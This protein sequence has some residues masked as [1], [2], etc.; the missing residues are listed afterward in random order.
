MKRFLTTLM[1]AVIFSTALSAQRTLVKGDILD[2]LTRQGEPAAVLQFFR[3]DDTAHPVAFTTT[4]LDG[5]FSQVLTG[6]G[7]Y[8]LYFSGIGRQDC[9][10]PFTLDGEETLDLGEILIEDDIEALAEASVTAQRPLVKM[11]VDRMTYNVADD[12]DSKTATVLDM[13]RKVPMVTVDGQDNI[14]VNGSSSFQVTVDGKPSQ[15]FSGNPSQIFKMMPASSVK[16][17]QV[18]TNPGVRYDAEGVGGVLNLI[19]NRE[20]T[21]GQSMADAFYG[22]VRAMGSTRGGGGGLFLTRQAGKFAWS[23]NGN[24]MYMSMPGT[25]TDV[26]RELIGG[27]GGSTLTHSESA[28]TLPMGMGT[29]SASYEI[30]PQNLISATAGL[31]H[32]GTSMDGLTSTTMTNAQGATLFG[33]DGTSLM[34]MTSN[35][36]TA[37]VD[38]QHLWDDVPARSLIFSYQFSGTPSTSVSE[39]TFNAGTLAGLDLTSRKTDGTQGSFDHTFQV[40]FT[41][42]LGAGGTF[43]AGAKYISRRNSSDQQLYLRN[44]SDWAYSDAGSLDYNF[45]NRIGALYSEFK[46][47]FGPVSLLGGARY[48]YTWQS[49]DNGGNGFSTRYGSLVPTAS[50]QWNLGMTQNIGLSYNMRISRPGISY[51]NPYVDTSDPTARSYG[52]GELEVERG[53]NISLVYNLY[54]PDWIVN[55][56]LRETLV[57]NGISPYSFYDDR[58][59]LN[60]TYGN[61]V[62]SCTT[63]LNA[64]INWNA[65]PDTRIFLNG[66]LNYVDLRS[67]VLGQRNSGLSYNAMLGVQ[68]ALPADI[69]LSANVV[70][71]GRNYT[72]Q[73]WS[74]GMSMAMIGATKSFLDDR[75]GIS[76]NYTVPLSG[77]KGLQMKSVTEGRDFRSVSVNT[78]PMENLNFSISWSFGKQGGAHVKSAR[79][80]ISNDDVLNVESTAESLGSS[81]MGSGGMM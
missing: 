3:A 55:L 38:Y 33:Y 11:E 74:T 61:I 49:V 9:R 47:T 75:L 71:M 19:T 14:T 16:D 66:G 43:N 32:F 7:A 2:A 41:T 4:D 80:S 25:T 54:S 45:F 23:L 24:G 40:D 69:S 56:T 60:T 65:G 17:I 12:V 21:G 13:L 44:G 22:S 18:I 48:E 34:K 5:A 42:P 27:V 46:T 81:M 50:L 77:G 68:Q 1:L 73:G 62:R 78:I 58:Q 79:K 30:D 6:K 15:L 63:G 72:L 67:D 29:F 26:S 37:S 39:N 53:H 20:T 10:I 57:G 52:N 35:S 31:M 36:I 64:F 8:T 76:I 51:L 59:L 28:M 70:A